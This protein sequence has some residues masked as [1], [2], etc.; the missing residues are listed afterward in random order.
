MRLEYGT[1]L[2]QFIINPVEYLGRPHDLPTD[3]CFVGI[4]FHHMKKRGG[5]LVYASVAQAYST[6][7]EPFALKGANI[8][9]NQKRDRQPYLNE[10]QSQRLLVDVLHEYENRAGVM[11][12]RVVVHKTTMYQEEELKGFEAAAKDT[13]PKIDMVWLRSTPFRIVRKGQEE[14][15]RWHVVCL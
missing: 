4:T 3:V 12:D 8:D 9:H 2:R 6:D 14:P 1:L 13:I 10:E 7:L 15:W 11:P 5:H